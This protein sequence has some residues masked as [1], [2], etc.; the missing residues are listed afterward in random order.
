MEM[1]DKLRKF[2][3]FVPIQSTYK[4]VKIDNIFM[5]TIFRLHCIPKV[6]ISYHDVKFTSNFWKALFEG[7]GTQLHFSTTYYPKTDG[8]TK[9][10]NQVVEDMIR[11]Y[12]MQQPAKLKE[13][14]HLVEFAYKNSY[15][16][17]IQMSPFE[18]LYGRKCRTP[19]S[20]GGPEDK[21]MVGPNMLAEMEEMVKV[22]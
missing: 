5:K 18:L 2:S 14:L 19:S 16:T 20:W 17:Y 3:H 9:K 1:V 10:L 7:L 21:L 8:Q 11:A 13:Y 15:H 12:V 22:V 4:A 6:I